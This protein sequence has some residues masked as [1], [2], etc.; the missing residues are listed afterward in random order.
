MSE[1][2]LRGLASPQ[3]TEHENDEFESTARLA[4]EILSDLR[5]STQVERALAATGYAALHALTVS[6]I[7]GVAVLS[8]RVGSYYLKQIAQATAETVPGLTQIRNEVVVR[9]S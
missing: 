6:M 4:S 5:L 3:K 1:S 8:G 2:T 9:R 7:A